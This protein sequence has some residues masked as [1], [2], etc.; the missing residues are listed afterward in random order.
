MIRCVNIKKSDLVNF[1]I[2]SDFSYAF[3]SLP[4]YLELM[5]KRILQGPK[6]V[7]R[8]RSLFLKMA[9]LLT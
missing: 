2:V 6:S 8:L 4:E 1:T 3:T 9:S 5:Q 7:L